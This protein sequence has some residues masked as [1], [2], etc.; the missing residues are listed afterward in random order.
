MCGILGQVHS[1]QRL[2]A[3]VL[4]SIEHRGPD[5]SGLWHTEVAKHQISLG[6]TRLSI[7]DLT[8]AGAQ[9]MH[10]KSGRWHIVFNGEIY[11]HLEL[12]TSHLPDHSFRGTSDTETLLE[13]IDSLGIEATL[14]LLNGMFAFAVLDTVNQCLHLVRDPFG[15][16]PLY[17]HN[18]GTHWHFASE[19][20]ALFRMGVSKT[21]SA[22]QL[23][24]FMLVQYVPSPATLVEN[25]NRL[26]PGAHLTVDLKSN[27][28]R[29]SRYIKPTQHRYC[30]RFEHAIEDYE[31]QLYRAVNR[32]MLSDVPVGVLLSGGIDSALVAA[33]RRR[34]SV[35]RAVLVSGGG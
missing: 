32:Q 20:K 28:H 35:A 9:P 25:V 21:V 34:V 16:K 18:Q 5:A 7:L 11:N 33:S 31:Q 23:N 30:S 29:I 15:I 1:K 26:G 19:M 6:H 27:R 4:E 13:A 14:P 24:T 17:Y 22:E 12:R 10:S 8:E 2:S 3:Q